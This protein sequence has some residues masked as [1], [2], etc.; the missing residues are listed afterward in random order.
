MECEGAV[1]FFLVMYGYSR[2][3]NH[4]ERVRG[5]IADDVR[6]VS[7]VALGG[8]VYIWFYE[9]RKTPYNRLF[10]GSNAHCIEYTVRI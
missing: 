10:S 5:G 8:I 4:H 2:C 9:G 7:V 3:R 1:A 6:R